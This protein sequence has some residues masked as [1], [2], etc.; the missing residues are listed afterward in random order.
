MQP[1][2]SPVPPPPPPPPPLLPP[3]PPPPAP[4]LPLSHH[5]LGI[6]GRRQSRM[7]N[8]NW[9][10]LPKHSVIGKHNI[11]TADKTD[12]EYELDTDHIE[13][14]F[15]HNHGQQHPKGQSRQS[16][17]GPLPSGHGAEMVSILSAKRSMNI[18]IFLKQFKRPV[19]DMIKD[20]KSGNGLNFGTGKLQELCRLLPDDGELKQLI[21]FK[22]DPSALPE[23]DLFMLMLVKIPSYEERLSCLVLKDEFFPIMDEIKE[24][25]GALTT[26]GKELLECDN[27]HSIIRLVLKTG[28]YM[29]AGGYAGS[30]IGFRMSSLLKLADTKANKPG[31]NLMH[32]V[33]MQAQ[34]ADVTLLM[35]PEQLR[36]IEAAAR[37]TKSDIEAEFERQVKKI[38]DAK[39]NTLKQEDLKAQMEDFLKKAETYLDDI[40]ADLE[41]LQSVSDSVAEYF[42]EDS[43]TFRLEECCSIFHSF[44]ERFF[45]AIQENKAREMA[46]VKRRR[47]DKLQN[48]VKRR[49]TATCS[50]RDKEMDNVALESVLQNLLTNRMSRRRPGTPSSVQESPMSDCPTNGSLSEISSEIKLPTGIQNYKDTFRANEMCKKGWSSATELTQYFSQEKVQLHSENNK[51][52]GDNTHKEETMASKKE[53]SQDVASPAKMTRRT[54]S[55]IKSISANTEDDEED[56]QDNSAEEAQKLREVSK[57]VLQYQSSRNSASSVDFSLENQ[58]SPSAKSSLPRQLTFDEETQRYADDPT[59]EDLVQLLLGPQSSSKQNLCRRHTLPPQIKEQNNPET[60]STVKSPNLVEQVKE[61]QPEQNAGDAPSNP[62][63]DFTDLPHNLKKSS[64]QDKNSPS[65]E[66]PSVHTPNEEF[67][68]LN[69]KNKSME[70]TGSHHPIKHEDVLP[71]SNWFKTENPGFFFSFLKRIGDM[72]KQQNSK[73]TVPTGTNS[74]V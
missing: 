27:L 33:V 45:R 36:H 17:R 59:N 9:E 4:G 70:S 54:L 48:A 3:P 64:D 13:E 26:A 18:G 12:G 49:S 14:L 43:Q 6:I 56:M 73:E 38:Q 51:P 55:T 21:G 42:C 7:R 63:F 39:A 16:L 65:A 20:I 74:S 57:K 25:I 40:K 52:E 34:K 35:F 44:C 47:I 19:K 58:K 66:D 31:M 29:N 50:S 41:E 10:T 53:N 8:F 68:E 61:S 11:W 69:S 2:S 15:S 62:V 23:A 24:F 5:G 71:R 46:E 1:G 60:Q 32:Y 28:N 30:A 67:Q 72:G 22:G 37:L